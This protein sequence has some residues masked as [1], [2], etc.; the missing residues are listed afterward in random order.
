MSR[1]LIGT[2]NKDKCNIYNLFKYVAHCLKAVGEISALM[3]L[4]DI[5][6]TCYNKIISSVWKG[7]RT[8]LQWYKN[9]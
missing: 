3:A 6:P 5:K 2:L 7:N 8:D 1:N 4:D 9:G